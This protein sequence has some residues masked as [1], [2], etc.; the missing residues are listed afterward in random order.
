VLAINFTIQ[1][2]LRLRRS[3]NFSFLTV[4]TL[5]SQNAPTRNRSR[6]FLFQRN[7]QRKGAIFAIKLLDDTMPLPGIEPG[8]QD[9]QSC[10][11]IH[12]TIGAV[13]ICDFFILE[14]DTSIKV[15]LL[16]ISLLYSS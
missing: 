16:S 2:R 10:V 3:D 11:L 14:N 4:L 1:K 15:L 12:Y 5:I 8:S 7:E 9:P 6:A 13:E